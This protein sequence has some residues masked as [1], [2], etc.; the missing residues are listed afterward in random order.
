MRTKTFGTALSLAILQTYFGWKCFR[1]LKQRCP[2]LI[3]VLQ[4]EENIFEPSGFHSFSFEECWMD[5]QQ[6]KRRDWERKKRIFYFCLTAFFLFYLQVT[7]WR[8]RFIVSLLRRFSCLSFVTKGL[9]RT[10]G[11]EEEKDWIF[12]CPREEQFVHVSNIPPKSCIVT[13]RHLSNNKTKERV[14]A[15]VI[16]AV[17]VRK[18]LQNF[19]VTFYLF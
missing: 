14:S 4:K 15:T 18:Y 2:L 8:F 10:E 16:L 12:E 6:W 9:R 17:C 1:M 11:K 5:G 3:L 7:S 19:V 13:S